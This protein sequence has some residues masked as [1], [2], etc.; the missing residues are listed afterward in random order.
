MDDYGIYR[1]LGVAFWVFVSG[2]LVATA[3]WAVKRF[4]PAS[5]QFWLLSPFSVLIRRL[6]SRVQ[7][8]RLEVLHRDQ[9]APGQSRQHPATRD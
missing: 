1:A 2:A 4:L 5:A 9:V 7:R 6:A 3:I 8:G